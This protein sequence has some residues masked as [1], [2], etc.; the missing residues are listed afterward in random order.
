MV[1]CSGSCAFGLM[2]I[3][4][5]EPS[6]PVNPPRELEAREL[7]RLL[8][9]EPAVQSGKQWQLLPWQEGRSQLHISMGCMSMEPFTWVLLSWASRVRN[10][11]P[12]YDT[13]H[14]PHS[15]THA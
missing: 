6:V 5:L 14:Q 8:V 3:T 1:T 15:L 9:A 11:T 4:N 10:H 2:V 12:Q 13:L 7:R